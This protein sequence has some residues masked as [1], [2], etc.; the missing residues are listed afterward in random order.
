MSSMF[1]NIYAAINVF[2]YIFLVLGY[3]LPFWSHFSIV[4][5]ESNIT[6]ALTQNCSGFLGL[7]TTCC[8]YG[9]FYCCG[10]YGANYTFD[11][12]PG[13]YVS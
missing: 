11:F 1:L 8:E 9:G 5:P 13:K 2:S 6:V 4:R 3:S 7:W 10:Y 12:D